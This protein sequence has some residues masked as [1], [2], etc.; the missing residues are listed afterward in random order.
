MR[1]VKPA[2]LESLISRNYF[3]SRS[4]A[5]S[6]AASPP[7]RRRRRG[8]VS[9]DDGE[10]AGIAR[11]TAGATMRLLAADGH[12]AQAVGDGGCCCSCCGTSS[13]CRSCA[14]CAGP[15]RTAARA[16]L[17]DGRLLLGRH[18]P[19]DAPRR[20]RAPTAAAPDLRRRRPV[21]RRRRSSTRAHPALKMPHPA[22]AGAPSRA[23]RWARGRG[24]SCSSARGPSEGR[25]AD[26]DAAAALRQHHRASSR[27][28]ARRARR[29]APPRRRRP[30][31]SP[32]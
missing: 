22:D 18:H 19:D 9:A 16:R 25:A 12:V 30:P 3:G 15:S 14:S 23:S 7:M 20:R 10:M 21:R 2:R 24:Q 8:S 28:A 4:D 17:R 26:D 32:T 29:R 27:R 11:P 6:R 1:A 5:N 13:S 31:P